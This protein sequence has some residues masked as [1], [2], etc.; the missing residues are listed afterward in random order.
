MPAIKK[1][2][3]YSIS[4]Q[5]AIFDVAPFFI[6]HATMTSEDCQLAHKSKQLLRAKRIPDAECDEK[7][8][9]LVELYTEND[10]SRK[11]II[12]TM[13]QEHSFEITYRFLC[14]FS[15]AHADHRK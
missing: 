9:R 1:P 13:A 15:L 12:E 11:E 3:D 4:G 10:A 2:S 14:L 5:F 8:A 6:L 7:R